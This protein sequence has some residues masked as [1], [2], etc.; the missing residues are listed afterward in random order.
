MALPVPCGGWSRRT[1]DVTRQRQSPS[2]ASSWTYQ[3]PSERRRG[4]WRST[5]RPHHTRSASVVP[6]T[7]MVTSWTNVKFCCEPYAVWGNAERG[8][9]GEWKSD[10]VQLPYHGTAWGLRTLRA[11]QLPSYTAYVVLFLFN[12][13]LMYFF[14]SSFLISHHFF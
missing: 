1:P 14:L 5:P 6:C 11:L 2:H 9:R 4:S 3:T 7:D 8:D 12:F 10:T 13:F